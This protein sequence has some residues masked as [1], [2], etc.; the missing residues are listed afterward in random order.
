MLK[1]RDIMT[2]NVV[3]IDGT[4]TIAEAVT[5]MREKGVGALIVER[6]SDDD[7]AR[8]LLGEWGGQPDYRATGGDIAYG[9]ITESDIAYKVAAYG[10]D[11]NAT[12]VWEVMT[13]PCIA[14]NPDLGVEYVARLFANS[15]V[16]HAPVIHNELMGMIS[17]MD[18][19]GRTDQDR[20]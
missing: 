10:R 12:H 2:T 13:R 20:S 16:H 1:A 15:R 18:I 11:P 7:G 17:V 5:L 19:I 3:T 9:L 4:A 14:V 6:P 8:F